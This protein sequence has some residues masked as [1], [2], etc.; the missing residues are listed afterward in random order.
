[1]SSIV[2]IIAFIA[3]IDGASI[4]RDSQVDDKQPTSPHP[5]YSYEKG[6]FL[7]FTS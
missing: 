1:M 4:V 6:A 3:L 2:L 7:A 5:L